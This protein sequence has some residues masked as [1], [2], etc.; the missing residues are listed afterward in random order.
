MSPVDVRTGAETSFNSTQADGLVTKGCAAMAE[1]V[2]ASVAKPVDSWWTVL[3]IDPVAR[4]LTPRL[5]RIT[6]LTPNVVTLVAFTIGMAGIGMF[7][8]GMLRLG[9]VLFEVRFLFDCLDG[10][11]ARL[12]RLSSER[13]AYLDVLCD[14]TCVGGAYLAVALA[15]S[16][17]HGAWRVLLP[18]VTAVYYVAMLA[19][20]PVEQNRDIPERAGGARRGWQRWLNDRRLMA[21]PT[22]VEVEA[23]ALFLAPLFLGVGAVR[24]FLVAAIGFYL[25]RLVDD[26][27]RVWVTVR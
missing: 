8:A 12:R 7:A 13:G 3:V 5:A 26:V 22:T 6:W 27:R 15:V 10:K 17:Q 20:V 23:A 9:A 1:K 11:I 25:L 24:V 19:H 14:T 4:R 21:Y 16:P 18:L 2:V